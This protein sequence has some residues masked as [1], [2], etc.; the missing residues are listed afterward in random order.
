M[1]LER[2]V[3]GVSEHE[4]VVAGL[5]GLSSPEGG[6]AGADIGAWARFHRANAAG[7]IHGRRI[8]YIAGRDDH[9][10]AERNLQ[11][12][13]RLINDD[14][15]FA[16]VPQVGRGLQRESSDLLDGKQVPFVGWGFNPGYRTSRFGFGFNGYLLAE[17]VPNLAS[18]GALVQGLDLRPGTTVAIQSWK[19]EGGTKGGRQMAA[20]YEA[21]GLDVVL[22]DD[23]LDETMPVDFDEHAS[24]LLSSAGGSP[25]DVIVM[26][27]R[28]ENTLGLTRALRR[29]GY[30]GVLNNHIT[31]APGLLERNP[32]IARVLD[33]VY[34]NTQFLPEEFGGQAIR[35]QLADLAA[36]GADAHMTFGGAIGYWC[37]DVFVQ[38]LQA[39]GPELRP[40]H[41]DKVIN[42]GFTYE[43]WGDIP[44]IGPVRFPDGHYHGAS[45]AALV[46]IVDGAYRPILPMTHFSLPAGSKK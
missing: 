44:G 26:S 2:P 1:G 29:R 40:E 5:S 20:S 13:Y 4:I 9:E 33:G 24:R 41:F 46:R 14:G 32:E 39:V 37:A 17:D 21:Y 28:F 19:G 7:G 36:L 3:R 8:R 11:E 10:D 35:Q 34:V 31:Y 38:M 43:P 6:Y 22:M 15:V 45:N 18:A 23:Q 25:P 12:L 30:Q 27:F 42:S 16:I